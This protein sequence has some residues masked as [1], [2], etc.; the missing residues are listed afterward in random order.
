MAILKDTYICSDFVVT[1]EKFTEICLLGN[2]NLSNFTPGTFNGENGPSHLSKI[3]TFNL[4]TILKCYLSL[5]SPC[6]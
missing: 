4:T 1:Y 5:I 2:K 6:L 3:T